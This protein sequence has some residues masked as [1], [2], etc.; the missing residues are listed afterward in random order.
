[1][2]ASSLL[3]ESA[4][5]IFILAFAFII[6]AIG[7]ALYLGHLRKKHLQEWAAAN[8]FQFYLKSG[9]PKDVLAPFKTLE[10]GHSRKLKHI[11]R[12]NWQG[13]PALFADFHYTTGSGKNQSHHSGTVVVIELPRHVDALVIR[14][15]HFG[16]RLTAMFG[17]DDI[18][19][20][21]VEF[22]DRFHVSSPN[23]RWAYDVLNPRNMERL[24]AESDFSYE[25]LRNQAVIYNGRIWQGPSIAC[26]LDLLAAIIKSIPN[27]AYD[28]A[29]RSAS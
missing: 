15:E 22:S 24:L 18:D 13:F 20:E 27:F 5:P 17:F 19:F 1:M 28:V 23:K 7:I 6:G 21:S 3:A 14:P 9:R 16:D 26:N 4:P 29:G 8:G 2:N 25:L 10:R 12:G 11:F